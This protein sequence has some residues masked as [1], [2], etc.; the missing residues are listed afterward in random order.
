MTQPAGILTAFTTLNDQSVSGFF[1]NGKPSMFPIL[2]N[3]LKLLPFQI[4]RTASS[5]TITVF[6]LVGQ[7]TEI[8]LI[9]DVAKI[10]KYNYG[11]YDWLIYTPE[12]LITTLP[13]YGEYYFHISDGT[14]TWY[15]DYMK[16]GDYPL[17]LQYFGAYTEYY[18]TAYQQDTISVDTNTDYYILNITNTFD[19]TD[20]IYQNGFED[21]LILNKKNVSHRYL[22]QNEQAEIDE[23]TGK[24]VINQIFYFD[25]Y[26]L[27]FIVGRN[28]ANFLNKIKQ[29]DKINIALPNTEE[30]ESYEF[31]AEIENMPTD[32]IKKITLK[33]RINF[34]NKSDTTY[35]YNASTIAGEL[36]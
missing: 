4:K 24:E 3:Y 15:F 31:E 36:G 32:E 2:A 14:N 21:I 12:T 6:K 19:L 17:S 11:T 27:T 8:D 16:L 13:K 28:V 18:T 35:N 20:K 29:L 1:V 25:E 33:Y 30:I 9:A 7:G 34:V 22:G 5:D 10:V 26:E 23:S